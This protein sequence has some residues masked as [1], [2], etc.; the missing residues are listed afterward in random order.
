MPSGL[1]FLVTAAVAPVARA[2]PVVN[3]LLR[4]MPPALRGFTRPAMHVRNTI[5]C[6]I[7]GLFIFSLSWALA[8]L[9]HSMSFSAFVIFGF[10]G[11]A[12][13]VGLGFA[14]DHYERSRG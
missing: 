4:T 10:V 8:H 14:W 3:L 12:I 2:R 7:L 5:C 9:S 1:L 11:V 13:M 6:L